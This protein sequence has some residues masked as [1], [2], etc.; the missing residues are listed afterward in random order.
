MAKSFT[1]LSFGEPRWKPNPIQARM[2]A[3]GRLG[4][5]TGRGYYDYPA[6]GP[7]RPEDPDPP[8]PGGGDGTLLAI[9]G[10]GPLADGLRERARDAGYE[11]REGGPAELV[12]DAGV[13]PAA[14][15]PGGAPLVL[16]CAASSLAARGEPGAIGFH[17]PAAPRREPPG[18]ADPPA[19]RAAVRGRGRRASSSRG[20]ASRSSGWRTRPASCSGASSAS[21]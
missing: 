8:A 15:L 21:S 11:L 7:H 2:V 6:D 1:E 17:A 14:E 13:Q 12:V 20:S 19:E 18:G 16:L 3:A 9:L 5:K 4:R 10:A